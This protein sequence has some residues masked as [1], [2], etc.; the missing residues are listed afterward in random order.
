MKVFTNEEL[1]NI[2][3]AI[4]V[5][6]VIFWIYVFSFPDYNWFF[7]SLI[8]V[9]FSFFLHEMGHKFVARKLGCMATYKI[10]PT[11][12]LIGIITI[13]FGLIIEEVRN[14]GFAFIALGFMEI[15]PYSF[16]RWGF[17]VVKLTPKDLGLISLAGVGINVI[18]AIFFKMFP[19]MW[20]FEKLAYFNA[21]FALFNLLPIPPLDGSKIFM[22]KM[23]LW[24][25]LMFITILLLFVF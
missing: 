11:G 14:F 7:V 17:K 9:F 18:L 13:F 1:R 12:L 19:G 4:L 5:M 22:W 20:L 6:S 10:W 15:M 16:G 21:L 3:V 24:L 25:F 8:I 23:W 2:I